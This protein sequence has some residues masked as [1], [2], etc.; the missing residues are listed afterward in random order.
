M[1]DM[2]ASVNFLFIVFAVTLFCTGFTKTLAAV[3]TWVYLWVD[4]PV[5]AQRIATT[6]RG[7]QP[8]EDEHIN[9]THAW[10][11]C[12]FPTPPPPYSSMYQ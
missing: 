12:A 3:L 9:D 11:L 6:V 5:G 8:V 10:V 2:L 4:K 7:L 1:G